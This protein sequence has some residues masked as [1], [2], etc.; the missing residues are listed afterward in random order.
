[1][2]ISLN[3]GKPVELTDTVFP[4]Q[5]LP[6]DFEE[7]YAMAEQNNPLLQWL[8]QE[9][10]VS[11]KD[12]QL[13]LA[14]SL[15]RLQAGYMSEKVVG[16]QYQGISFGIAVPLLE[17]RNEVKY[18]RA[19]TVAVQSAE[20]DARIQFYNNLKA[21]HEK[22]VSLRKSLDDYRQNLQVYSSTSLL[23]KAL[24]HGELSLAE[25][26]YEQTFYYESFNKLI[27]LEK[28]LNDTVARL[29][30]YR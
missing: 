21:L 7:W 22:A 24:D 14:M 11:R 29:N 18:A 28:E 20:N 4:F 16:Q 8:R 19:R 2:L 13:S 27:A 12:E 25:Y 10:L 5:A 15:P 1:V 3:G 30:M 17:N 6:A 26:L 23:L 9:V